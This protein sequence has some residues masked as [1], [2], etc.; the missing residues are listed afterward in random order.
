[1]KRYTF[2]FEYEGGTYIKQ[3][4]ALDIK[5]AIEMWSNLLGPEIPNFNKKKKIQL[6]KESQLSEPTPIAG[7]ENVWH[8]HLEIGESFGYLNIVATLEIN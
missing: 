5:S 1:M 8:L 2:I 6:L 3:V 4:S 7:M